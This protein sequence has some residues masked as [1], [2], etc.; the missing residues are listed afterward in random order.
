MHM[1]VISW[2]IT[3]TFEELLTQNGSPISQISLSIRSSGGGDPPAP[4]C[5]WEGSAPYSSLQVTPSFVR[6]SQDPV[7]SPPAPPSP[8]KSHQSRDLSLHCSKYNRLSKRRLTVLKTIKRTCLFE[9]CGIKQTSPQ[10]LLDWLTSVHPSDLI[11]NTEEPG[12][13]PTT[14]QIPFV[15]AVHIAT[16]ALVDSPENECNLTSLHHHA[17]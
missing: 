11:I 12:D 16:A 7:W 9:V 6:L 4:P 15:S 13:I 14:E 10:W 17:K 8:N 1:H 3:S 2:L 5:S